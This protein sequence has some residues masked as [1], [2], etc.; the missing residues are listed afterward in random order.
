V[1]QALDFAIQAAEGLAKAHEAGIVHRDIKP[2]NLMVTGDG[3]L[4]ILDFG[5]AKPMDP[6]EPSRDPNLTITGTIVGT[7]AYISPE[8]LQGI[9]PDGRSDLFSLGLVLYEMIAGANPFLRNSAGETLNAILNACPPPLEERG[10]GIVTAISDVIEKAT[11]KN[12]NDR[13]RDAKEMVATLRSIEADSARSTASATE[14]A[15]RGLSWARA[16][17]FFGLPEGQIGVAVLPIQ[18]RCADPNLAAA[19]IGQVLTNAF[20]Q[21]LTDFPTLYVISPTRLEGLA[22]ASGRSWTDSVPDLQSAHEIAVD[23]RAGAVLSGSLSQIGR[24]YVLNA[25]LTEVPSEVILDT[26]QVQSTRPDLL[27]SELTSGLSG[28]LLEEYGGTR[29]S[30]SLDSPAAVQNVATRSIEAYARFLRGVG[31]IDEGRWDEAIGEL[32]EAVEADSQMALAWS[33]L[34][35]AYSFGGDDVKARA[36][37]LKA[38]EFLDRVNERERRWIEL[39]GLWVNTMNGD[40]YLE[41]MRDYIRDFPDE[42][43]SYLYAGLAEEHLKRDPSA[44]LDWYAKAYEIVPV[45]Y[46]VTQSIVDC[47]LKLGRRRE[48]IQALRRYLALPHL[49]DHARGQAES[50]LNE[51]ESE[52]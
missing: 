4:K 18:N 13:F 38:K 31:L 6:E 11:A 16:G 34:S 12:P 19:D 26:F 9:D 49:R 36:S 8:R 27:L 7:P 29:A 24:T 52:L 32:N 20:V 30:A 41:R 15:R 22:Q 21:I 3:L 51:L 33:S 46:P 1:P 25:T 23:A 43:D 47:Q 5:L 50:R 14:P 37:H 44:A 10:R 17:R 48:A 40:L 35:C 39:D 28:Q 45:Y 42:R 2:E